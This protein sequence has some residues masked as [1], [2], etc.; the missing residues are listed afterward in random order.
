MTAA[1][2]AAEA[3]YDGGLNVRH[4]V[5]VM[6]NGAGLNQNIVAPVKPIEFA[7]QAQKKE[8]A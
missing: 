3:G 1:I 7:R 4:A 6:V 5:E 8:A 2:E